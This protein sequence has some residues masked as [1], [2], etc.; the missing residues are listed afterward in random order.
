MIFISKLERVLLLK[1]QAPKKLTP[2]QTGGK[3]TSIRLFYTKTN[4]EFNGFKTKGVS[5]KVSFLNLFTLSGQKLEEYSNKII[6]GEERIIFNANV[7][8][9]V[10]SFDTEPTLTPEA[11]QLV[12]CRFH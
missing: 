9:G 7:D 1:H 3:K 12:D 4:E 11:K 6:H 5:G 8:F 10:Y 2:Q